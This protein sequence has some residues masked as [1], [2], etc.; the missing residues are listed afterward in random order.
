MNTAVFEPSLRFGKLVKLSLRLFKMGPV[1]DGGPPSLLHPFCFIGCHNS[2]GLVK[3]IE[4][5]DWLRGITIDIVGREKAEQQNTDSPLV[6]T[7]TQSIFV[8]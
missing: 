5:S 8:S 3:G 4:A 2:K 1:C 7:L 6:A